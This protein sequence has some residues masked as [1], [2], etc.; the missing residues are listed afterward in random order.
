[1]SLPVLADSME[2]YLAEVGT[3]PTLSRK[4]EHRLAVDFY[5]NGTIESAHALVTANLR[6]VLKIANEYRSYGIAFKDLIQEGNLGLMNAVKKFNPYKGFKLI[7]YAVWWIKAFIQEYIMKTRGIVKRG[8]RDLKKQLFYRQDGTEMEALPAEFDISGADLSL[9]AP[10][11]GDGS[12]THLDALADPDARHAEL[13]AESNER[14]FQNEKIS[15]AL[16]TLGDRERYVVEKRFLADEPMS[17]QKIG[18]SLD[19]T[20]ERVRQIEKKALTR[21][22]AIMAPALPA[23]TQAH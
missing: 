16:A 17:L 9:D 13:I 10:L 7:T 15:T 18:E 19:I 20:R 22:K 6:F 3:F 11:G 12:T 2:A 23:T 21:L 1:M 14:N 5:E 8:A 4:E